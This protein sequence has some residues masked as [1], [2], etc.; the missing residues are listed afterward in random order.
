MTRN[1]CMFAL[2]PLRKVDSVSTN[3]EV[4]GKDHVVVNQELMV[5]GL[6]NGPKKNDDAE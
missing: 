4:H 1:G 6:S 3:K 2:A 5:I